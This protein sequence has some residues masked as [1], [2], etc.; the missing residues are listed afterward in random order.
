MKSKPHI[1]L[2]GI[3]SPRRKTRSRD[4]D[5]SFDEANPRKKPTPPSDCNVLANDEPVN[6]NRDG[7]YSLPSCGGNIENTELAL[8]SI[9]SQMKESEARLF[10]K[11]LEIQNTS[12][13]ERELSQKL[14]EKVDAIS[15]KVDA[16]NVKAY[17]QS[18]QIDILN[19]KVDA[20]NEKAN[21]QSEQIDAL[22]VRVNTQSEKVNALNEKVDAQSEKV[23]ALNMK[24]GA[25]SEKVDALN[26]K[27]D[28]QSEKVDA[29]N[30]K[31][32]AQ[33]EKVDALN[34]KVDA[35]SQKVDAQ[36][37]KID[38]LNMNVKEAQKLIKIIY[39]SEC[40]RRIEV[41][42]KLAFESPNN[43]LEAPLTLKDG[44]SFGT[45]P[46]ITGI[47]RNGYFPKTPNKLGKLSETQLHDLENFFDDLKF[48]SSDVE[49]RK[50]E[51]KIWLLDASSSFK[52]LV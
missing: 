30:M 40:N 5:S 6:P 22:N 49:K 1:F 32:G 16:L 37:E 41:K 50:L 47:V 52:N 34:V 31:V 3:A 51:F 26:A 35:Q 48:T 21:V 46:P 11:M 24:V 17:V 4:R 7:T 20:L 2:R 23:D 27:V 44:P 9:S 36:S 38:A 13:T 14:N 25:Q 29:L 8:N 19:V 42:N 18:E 45:K 10:A 33:S 28:A 39:L 15:V 43:D 12:K